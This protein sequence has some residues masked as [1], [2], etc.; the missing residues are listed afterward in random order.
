MAI[1]YQ[2]DKRSGII[3]AYDSKSHW[4]KEKQQSR[5]TRHLIGRV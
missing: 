1:A 4:N 2:K 3:Y 5:S